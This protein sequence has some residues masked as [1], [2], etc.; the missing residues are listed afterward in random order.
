NYHLFTPLLYQVATAGLEPEEIAH[1]VRAILR[2]Q[3]NVRFLVAGVQGV[4]LDHRTVQTD[5]GVFGYD[6]LILAAGS[7]TNFFGLKSV[8]QVASGLKDVDE[9]MA[10]RNRILAC[11]EAAAWEQDPQRRRSLLTFVVVGGGP[12]GVE[13]AGALAELV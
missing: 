4:D 13:F 3:R 5:A 6:Y 9:A 1:P 12:T 8:E 10:L 7:T 11:F 2:G